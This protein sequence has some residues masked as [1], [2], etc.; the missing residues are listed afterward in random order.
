[1]ADLSKAPSAR[2]SPTAYY[3]G[4]VWY[5]NG[6]ASRAF[7]SRRGHVLFASIQP[8]IR[9][10]SLFNGG[11][12]PETFILQRHRLIDYLLRDALEKRGI[13]TVVEIASGMSPRGYRFKREFGEGIDYIE[14]D[15]PAMAANKCRVL[16]KAGFPGGW[17]KVVAVDV[18]VDSGPL[19]ME[20]AIGPVLGGSAPVAIVTEGL[21][22]YLSRDTV[23]RMW[24]RLAALCSCSGSLYLTD[25]HLAST[26]PKDLFTRAWRGGIHLLTRGKTYLHFTDR[27][28]AERSLVDAGFA[29]SRL[30]DPNAYADALGLRESARENVVHVLEGI[31]DST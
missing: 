20:E 17:H 22:H 12:L 24:R 29:R 13:K 3:T 7:Y 16:E 10:A 27:D 1:M 21:V 25:L 4:H 2:I 18:T 14:A 28:D 19:C 15:L 30:H 9:A 11:L 8:I 6:L 5:R 31:V 23:T 26:T